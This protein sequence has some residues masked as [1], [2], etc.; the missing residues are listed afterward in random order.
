MQKMMNQLMFKLS[1]LLPQ[2]QIPPL[3][4]VV[5]TVNL[6]KFQSGND[7]T[8]DTATFRDIVYSELLRYK[9][10]ASIIHF[11]GGLSIDTCIQM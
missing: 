4:S 3:L 6:E 10:K 7:Q 9:S 1:V 5:S 2:S 8:T 11:T